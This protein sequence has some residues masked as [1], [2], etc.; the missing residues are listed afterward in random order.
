L[1]DDFLDDVT[2]KEIKKQT[3]LIEKQKLELEE[4]EKFIQS[5]ENITFF[6]KKRG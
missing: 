6:R 4:Q 1:N 3:R 2:S 5:L